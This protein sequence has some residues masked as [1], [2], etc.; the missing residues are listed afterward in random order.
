MSRNP[1]Q[2]D[3][4]TVH[5]GLEN[6]D[7]QR[8]DQQVDESQQLYP[9]NPRARGRWIMEDEADE[10]VDQAADQG[11]GA[12]ANTQGQR[13]G[14]N[15]Q[16]GGQAPGQQNGGGQGGDQ[17]QQTQNQP[18]NNNG[19]YQIATRTGRVFRG[20]TVDDALRAAL[21]ALDQSDMTQAQV[22]SEMANLRRQAAADGGA[23]YTNTG[24]RG[25]GREREA[26]QQR[27]QQR[28]QQQSANA[29]EWNDTEFYN[30][31]AKD[32]RK[33]MSDFMENYFG[34]DPRDRIDFAHDISTQVRDRIEIADF[35]ATN[36]DFPSTQQASQMVLMRLNE[37]GQDI[38]SWN[39][40]VAFDQLT[41]EGILHRVTGDGQQQNNNQQQNRQQNYQQNDN[42]QQNRGRNAP[43][44]PG[45][46]G[47]AG[48][49]GGNQQRTV[50]GGPP[51]TLEEFDSWDSNKQRQWLIAN[52]MYHGR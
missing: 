52:N 26:Q 28:N 4:G 19:Q 34:G 16:G 8:V 7:Q 48:A 18:G 38:T 47:G 21:D 23:T 1:N 33:A 25:Y 51:P 42:Q 2:Q 30:Q 14:Q 3:Q 9:D 43:P 35:L 36:L 24:N 40:K 39:L 37:D 41:H 45:A 29:G 22:R 31:F 27:N 15:N 50:N 32:P 10:Y 49:G 11:A 46:G 6:E 20:A 13:P 5:N 17:G 12:G 44:P